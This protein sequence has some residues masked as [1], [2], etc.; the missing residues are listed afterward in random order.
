MGRP[1]RLKHLHHCISRHFLMGMPVYFAASLVSSTARPLYAPHLA[2]ARWGSFF[3]WQF[4]HSE[5]PVAVRKSCERRSAVRRVE[6]RLFGFGMTTIPFVSAPR[7]ALRTRLWHL[8]V[9]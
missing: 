9:S 6:W 2:Q 4:G 3:S 8:A 7:P 1:R 5:S